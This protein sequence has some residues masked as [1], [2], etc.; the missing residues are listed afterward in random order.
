MMQ[1]QAFFWLA[2]LTLALSACGEQRAP[3]GAP[4]SLQ[5]QASPKSPKR[6]V[7]YDLANTADQN[8]LAPGVGWWYNWSPNPNGGASLGVGL[9]FVP[10]LWNGSFDTAG[11]ESRVRSLGATYLLVMNEPNLTGQANLTPSQAADLWPRYEQV[12]RDTGVK[13]VGPQITW[14]DLPGYN[15]P[16]VWLDAFYAA[17]RSKNGGRDPSI[18]F[19]GFHWYDY[20]LGAQLDRLGKYGK[21]LWVTEFANWHAGDGS[22]QIDSVA[23]QKAQ[24]ADMVATLE[25]RADVFRYAWFT[26]RWT[27]DTHFSSLLGGAGQLTELGQYYLSLPAGAVAPGSGTGACGPSNVALNKPAAASSAENGGTPARAAFDGSGA[28]RWSSQRSDDQWLQ[29]DLGSTQS[30]CSVTLVWEAAYAKTF[31]MQVSGDGRN[32]TAAS[33]VTNGMRGAQTVA[34]SGSGRYVRLQGLTRATG[35]GYSL[36]ELGVLTK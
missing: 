33:P 34:V 30:L 32:W 11:V 19:L 6:G 2:G 26:G 22:A 15:D 29:V 17:Y 4:P 14:G 1:K 8:A 23:K 12:A 18:D 10:M 27:N 31:Q 35:Y 7:A 36:W 21:P 25:N 28:T 20:G 16:V 9:D 5:P 24:M 3:A 13:I